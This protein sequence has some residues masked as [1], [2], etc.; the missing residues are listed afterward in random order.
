MQNKKTLKYSEIFPYAV[1]PFRLLC[2]DPIFS[3]WPV[4]GMREPRF[5]RLPL[6][7]LSS[8]NDL[9]VCVWLCEWEREREKE[10]VRAFGFWYVL[11]DREKVKNMCVEEKKRGKKY[12]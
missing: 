1:P 3:Q 6:L 5:K 4:I 11:E 2:S 10:R 9:C 8:V 12:K 7:P